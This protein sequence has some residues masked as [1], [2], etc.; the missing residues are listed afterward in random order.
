MNMRFY[1]LA[2]R[3]GLIE[4]TGGGGLDLFFWKDRLKFHVDLFEFTLDA[5]PRLRLYASLHLFRFF[6]IAAGVDDVF[7]DKTRDYFVGGGLRFSD[8]DIKFLLSFLPLP[9]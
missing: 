4:S 6:T 7:N 8:D 5:A 3:G 1:F 2:L 9:K